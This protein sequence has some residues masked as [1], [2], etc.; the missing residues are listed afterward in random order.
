MSEYLDD[1]NKKLESARKRVRKGRQ[2]KAL[3]DAAP[4][5][6]EIIDG[7]ITL[8]IN[9]GYGEIPLTRDEYLESHGAVRALKRMRNLMDAAEK[10]EVAA[11]Q[12]V[13]V[14]NDQVEQFKKDKELNGGQGQS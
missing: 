10:D 6:F 14:I 13:K 12:E 1:L 7:E 9:K 8:E 3:K 4:D 5:L 11:A 2:V